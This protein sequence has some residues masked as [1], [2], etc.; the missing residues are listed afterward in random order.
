MIIGISGPSGAGKTSLCRFLAQCL[1]DAFI[2][3]QDWYYKEPDLYPPTANFCDPQY[4]YV[5]R[6]IA[7]VLAL[8]RGE[9]VQVQRVDMQTFE[10]TNEYFAVHRG[11]YLLIEGMTI[12]RMAEIASIFDGRLYLAPDLSLVRRRKRRRDAIERQKDPTVIEEQ[13]RWVER[14]Y[15][16]DMATMPNNVEFIAGRTTL[17][18]TCQLALAYIQTL[19]P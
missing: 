1:P 8:A 2:L 6:F 18:E 3:Q 16:V 13:L 9:T 14:E 4:L 5:D 11:R 19:T 12:F 17:V 10:R 15:Q 7:D